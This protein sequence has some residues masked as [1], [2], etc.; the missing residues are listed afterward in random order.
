M[1]EPGRQQR[2]HILEI[3]TRTVR[4]SAYWIDR[5]VRTLRGARV[6]WGFQHVGKSCVLAIDLRSHPSSSESLGQT[7]PHA[8]R[9]NRDRA[10]PPRTGI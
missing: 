8:D 1:S 5:H 7:P 4:A 9:S 3:Q 10:R 6:V 2:S